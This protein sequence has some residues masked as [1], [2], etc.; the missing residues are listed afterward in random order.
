MSEIELLVDRLRRAFEGEAWHGPALLEILNG[1]DAAMA[2]ARPI[3]TAHTIWELVLHVAAWERV[4]SG[5]LN[6][7]AL[8]LRDEENFP[9]IKQ[10]SEAAWQEAIKGLRSAHAD[11]I[12]AVSAL[13]ERRLHDRVPG[14]DYDVRFMLA[15]VIEHAAYHGGQMALLKRSRR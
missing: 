3:P 7:Q 14:K 2:A 6:G 13:A 1:V 5:R 8:T 12:R 11:L 10:T 9:R 15:G 4:V